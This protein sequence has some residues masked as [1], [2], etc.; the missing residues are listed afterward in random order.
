MEKNRREVK[1]RIA[2]AVILC[3]FA[4]EAGEAVVKVSPN[5]EIASIASARDK[6]R[7]LRNA[8]K[9]KPDERVVV[10]LGSGEYRVSDTVEFGPEDSCVIYRGAGAAHTRIVG[11][12]RVAVPATEVYQSG[13]PFRMKEEAVGKVRVVYCFHNKIRLIRVIRCF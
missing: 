13:V 10:E 12:V 2:F 6:V 9:I 7:A 3:A 11:G 8:G 4:A 1:T 5:G